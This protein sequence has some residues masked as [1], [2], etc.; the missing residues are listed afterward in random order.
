MIQIGGVYTTFC[1]EKSILLQKHRDSNGRCIAILF[2]SAGVR[3]RFD[4]PDCRSTRVALYVWQQISCVSHVWKATKEYLNQRGTKI[5]VFRVRFR[6]P[7]SHPF[8]P[9]FPPLF[10]LQALFTFP[11][12]LPS[13]PPPV[14]PL[15]RLPENSDLGTPLI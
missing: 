5:R 11:P 6:A 3:R 10:P 4:S 1:Q 8:S 9:H 2:K 12:F 14:S 13:S 7:S 15:F